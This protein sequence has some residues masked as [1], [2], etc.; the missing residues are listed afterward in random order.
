MLG[1]TGLEENAVFRKDVGGAQHVVAVVDPEREVMQAPVRALHV[2]HIRELVMDRGRAHPGADLGLAVVVAHLLAQLEAEQ[3]LREFA[4][5]LD[6]LGEQREMIDAPH[7]DAAAGIFLRQV[8]QVRMQVGGR[9]EFLLLVID[10]HDVAVGIAEAERAAAAEIAVGPAE[11][12]TGV[13]DRLGA[14]FQR[15]RARRA[16]GDAADA[17]HWPRR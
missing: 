2:H 17:R 1:R 6:V 3:F 16:P 13:R 9:D 11:A 5:G 12:K 7:A 8:L 10:F 14:A 4:V 15:L